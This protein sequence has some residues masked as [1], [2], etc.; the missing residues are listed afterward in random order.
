MVRLIYFSFVHP[1][2]ARH[3]WAPV[4]HE[5]YGDP[6]VRLSVAHAAPSASRGGPVE[7]RRNVESAGGNLPASMRCLGADC[8]DPRKVFLMSVLKLGVAETKDRGSFSCG[9]THVVATKE[10]RDGLGERPP[11]RGKELHEGTCG[12][13]RCVVRCRTYSPAW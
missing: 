10:R 6:G 12:M 2:R 13:A 1:L 7:I 3:T 11:S 4:A 5:T 8:A 9:H